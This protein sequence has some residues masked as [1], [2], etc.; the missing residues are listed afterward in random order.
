MSTTSEMLTR[1]IAKQD[2]ARKA[3]EDLQSKREAIV[4]LADDEGRKDLNETEDS[5]FQSL[6]DELRALD[7]QIAT[8][9][10][11]I[12]ELG[13]EDKRAGDAAAAFR[14]AEMTST[15]V[16]VGNE[17]RMYEKGNG[18]SYLQD[19]MKAQI[20]GDPEA[21]ARLDRH[22][23]EVLIDPE[24]RDLDRTDSTGGYFVPPLWLSEY[25]ELARAGRPT[26]NLVTNLPLPPGT[27]S[28]N[29]PKISTGTATAVQAADNSAVQETDLAD[30]SVQAN[31]KTIA[32]QQDVA[33]QLL[34]QSPFNFDQVVFA[35]LTADYATRVDVQVLNGQNSG[36]E[37]KGILA[38]SGVNTVA[39]TSTTP[40]VGGL[41][42]KIADAIQK[43]HTNRFMAPTVIVMHPRRWAWFLATLDST[44]RPLVVPNGQG[45][46]N[47][48]AG[49]TD[50]AS[51]QVVG[52]LQG[53]P[54][55]TD[56]SIPTTDSTNQD[57]IIVM[58]AQDCVLYESALRTRVLPEV[59]SGTLTVR[60][61]V[62]GYIAFTAE[63][64]PAGITKV[65]GTGL[66]TPSF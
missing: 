18:R 6:T 55:V 2:E 35:D 43:I 60:L 26:A 56:P 66:S 7:E 53:L 41:Y 52:S 40:T 31:V 15:R 25:V 38:A 34:D 65:T 39:Y 23:S 62:Y 51:Q 33:L 50:V 44:G 49:F 58:R 13:D 3:R 8:R 19:L 1:L 59:G 32:G 14:R 48:I 24:Y 4:Q 12:T 27:D 9:D 21:R 17:A 11:R 29:I 30:T 16:K 20:N 57:S 47:A 10:A 42:P 45:P 46:N 5:E 61:Q 28:I 37:V 54:V 63:R 64:Q 36:G 22:A